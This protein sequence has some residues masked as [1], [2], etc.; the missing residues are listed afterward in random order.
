[1]GL[2]KWLTGQN[3][4]AATS[5]KPLAELPFVTIQA[6]LRISG[7]GVP[8]SA[9]GGQAVNSHMGAEERVLSMGRIDLPPELS[10]LPAGRNPADLAR[11]EGVALRGCIGAPAKASGLTSRPVEPAKSDLQTAGKPSSHEPRGLVIDGARPKA[12]ANCR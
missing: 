9:F 4:Q 2:W 7:D 10:G 8:V 3:N 1:M 11:Q 12:P 5:G 6:P